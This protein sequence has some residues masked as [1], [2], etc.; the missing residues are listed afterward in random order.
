MIYLSNFRTSGKDDRAI[1][2]AAITPKWYKGAVW[3]DL[4]PILSMVTGVKKGEMTMV[5]YIGEYTEIVYKHDLDQ[6]AKELDGHVLLCYC[7]KNELCHRLL[8]GAYL[9]IETGIEVQEIG[10]FG[11]NWQDLVV[12]KNRPMNL[13]LSEDEKDKYNLHGKFEHDNI[14]GHWREL[15]A[16]GATELF[17]NSEM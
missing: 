6:L 15:K 9:N 1:S 3:K 4:A 10:G 2:I 13:I 17:I 7:P 11:E 8:L 16:I 12:N 14:I 5:E